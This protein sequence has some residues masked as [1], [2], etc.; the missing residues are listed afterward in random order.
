MKDADKASERRRVPRIE[1]D[2]PVTVSWKG[3][4]FRWKAQE[5]SEYG[6]LLI[7]ARKELVGEELHLSLILDSSQPPLDL[8]GMVAYATDVGLGIRFKNVP[9]P[10]QTALRYYVLSRGIGKPQS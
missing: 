8:V 9:S 7:T 4:Q 5:F 6:I 10:D 2:F 1:V 3:K